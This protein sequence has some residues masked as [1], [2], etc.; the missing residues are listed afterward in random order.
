LNLFPKLKIMNYYFQIK[1]MNLKSD[2]VDM[3][4][5][6]EKKYQNRVKKKTVKKNEY[7]RLRRG[8]YY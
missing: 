1:I 3:F 8:R 2:H 7:K 4:I 6:I 5:E